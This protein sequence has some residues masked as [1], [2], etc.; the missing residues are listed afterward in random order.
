M[1]YQI[2]S[3]VGLPN[4]LKGLH[5][6]CCQHVRDP[7]RKNKHVLQWSTLFIWFIWLLTRTQTVKME[8]AR[9]ILW[10]AKTNWFLQ[11]TSWCNSVVFF[12]LQNQKHK[13]SKH[14]M[15]INNVMKWLNMIY[16][17]SYYARICI[18]PVNL[19]YSLPAFCCGSPILWILLRKVHAS[20][21]W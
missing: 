8:S 21:Q 9:H 16:Q 4:L 18:I 17:I 3:I 11:N 7:Y 2:I 19:W 15:F 14:F 10:P 12:M 1:K 13:S 6:T 20:L 5:V